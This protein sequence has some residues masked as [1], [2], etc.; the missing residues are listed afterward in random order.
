M[1]GLFFF[2]QRRNDGIA[3]QNLFDGP[4]KKGKGLLHE[5]A[6]FKAFPLSHHPFVFF[7][8]IIGIAK[9]QLGGNIFAA[10]IFIGRADPGK[11]GGRRGAKELFCL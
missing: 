7:V 5:N 10:A 4:G 1:G 8:Q 6:V 9:A 11:D 3:D 2:D